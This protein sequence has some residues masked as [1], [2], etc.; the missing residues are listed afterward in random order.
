MTEP[1]TRVLPLHIPTVAFKGALTTDALAF[2]T[3]AANLDNGYEVGGGNTKAAIAQLLR[4][5]ASALEVNNQPD[6]PWSF[7][8][9][10]R[11][12]AGAR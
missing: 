8:D 1:F 3:A 12:Q 5:A 4:N 6:P 11:S 10:Q 7:Y 9:H 2:R